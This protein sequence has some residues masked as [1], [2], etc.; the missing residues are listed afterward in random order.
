MQRVEPMTAFFFVV[1]VLAWLAIFVPATTRARHRAPLTSTERFKR[2]WETIALPRGPLAFATA[3]FSARPVHNLNVRTLRLGLFLFMCACVA[4]TFGALFLRGSS[5]LEAQLASDAALLLYVSWLLHESH[6]SARS[7][8]RVA[9][10][11][12]SFERTI[13]PQWGIDVRIV[14]A[15][16]EGLDEVDAPELEIPETAFA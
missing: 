4:V 3:S 10:A 15:E 5:V 7:R 14:D 1:L 16:E 12:P 2:D 8:P 13:R 11:S 9:P 6:K